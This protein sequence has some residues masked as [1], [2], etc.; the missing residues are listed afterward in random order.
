MRA[1]IPTNNVFRRV[2]VAITLTEKSFE[3][4]LLQ[5]AGYD[6]LVRGA[7]LSVTRIFPGGVFISLVNSAAHSDNAIENNMTHVV[8]NGP[9]I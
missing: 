7:S 4:I 6:A 5:R 2:K 9:A 3:V 8:T 1:A